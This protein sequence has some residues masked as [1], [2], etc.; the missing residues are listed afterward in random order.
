MKDLLKQFGSLIGAGVAAACCLGLPL[1]LSTL[2]AVGLGFIVHDAYLLP[3]F[4]GFIALSLRSLYRSARRHARLQPFW[5]ALIG[6]T[7]ASVALWLLVPGTYPH[8]W[9]MYHG[10]L[11][12]VPCTVWDLLN[13]LRA[14]ASRTTCPPNPAA[15]PNGKRRAATRAAL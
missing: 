10:L 3:L 1:V 4:V 12:L 2:G 11:V 7:E 6:G 5:L 9:A 15:A 8:T 13:R 14:P